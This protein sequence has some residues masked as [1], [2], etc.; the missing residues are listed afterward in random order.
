[1]EPAPNSNPTKPKFVIS[2]FHFP[3]FFFNYFSTSKGFLHLQLHSPPFLTAPLPRSCR[4]LHH[5][6]PVR[7]PY[8]PPPPPIELSIVASRGHLRRQICFVL[9]CK[10]WVF[11]VAL[12]GNTSAQLLTGSTV[13]TVFW[14]IIWGF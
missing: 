5:L 8:Q 4:D 12:S 14:L 3:T 13:A 2:Y 7:S 11:M 6:Y 9:G 1:M 10:D